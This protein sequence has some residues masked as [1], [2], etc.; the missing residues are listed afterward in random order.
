M[1]LQG[2]AAGVRARLAGVETRLDALAGH[3][4]ARLTE[5]GQQELLGQQA[6]ELR[7]ALAALWPSLRERLAPIDALRA[8]LAPA[9]EVDAFGF[10]RALE[11]RLSPV[12]EFLHGT[13]WRVEARGLEALPAEGPLVVVANHGGALPWDALVLKAAFARAH[14]PRELRPLLD[15]AALAAPLSGRL[16]ARLGAVPATPDNALRLLGAGGAVAV[17]PEGSRNGARPWRERY[18]VDHFGRGGFAKLALRTGAAIVPCAI[19]GSEETSAPFVRAGWLTDRLGLGEAGAGPLIDMVLALLGGAN[20]LAALELFPLPSRWSLH[21]G[22][23]LEVPGGA[24]RASDP[25]DGAG[26]RAAHPRRGPVDARRRPGRPALDLPVIPVL[27]SPPKGER[28]RERRGFEPFRT[29]KGCARP[30]PT[31]A[32]CGTGV[33]PL[34]Q[35]ARQRPLL[36]GAPRAKRPGMANKIGED[37]SSCGACE[38]ECP[39]QAISEGAD[40]Y[41]IDA[42]KCDECA[43]SGGDPSCMAVCPSD[44]IVKA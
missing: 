36:D 13:W 15:A 32:T 10:D 1:G 43:A 37:C 12:V 4:S 24:E 16:A 44:C 42:A 23:P 8:L 33:V 17:F 19:V 20:P 39:N 30:A 3:A 9:G 41:E 31:R 34:R 25:E 6:A 18:Q 38:P 29:R 21:F 11:E 7:R 22:A 28:V 27:P 40:H 5:L 35:G 14:P 26:P 2:L